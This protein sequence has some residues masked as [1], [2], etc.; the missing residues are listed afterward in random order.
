MNVICYQSS[1][2]GTV[3]PLTSHTLRH[4]CCQTS[5]DLNVSAVV[6]RAKRQKSSSKSLSEGKKIG[7]VIQGNKKFPKIEGAI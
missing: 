5:M 1:K 3:P 4:I 7:T 2:I 6:S